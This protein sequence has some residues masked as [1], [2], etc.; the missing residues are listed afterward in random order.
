MENPAHLP[1]GHK[2]TLYRDEDGDY[3]LESQLEKGLILHGISPN[4]VVIKM[5]ETIPHWESF[6]AW[7]GDPR[8][9]SSSA[10]ETAQTFENFLE[11][12]DERTD[13]TARELRTAYIEHAEEALRIYREFEASEME[14]LSRLDPFDGNC[15][16]GS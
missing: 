9:D 5:V 6:K 7:G 3:V 14:I 16:A 13:E 15:T 10:K 2:F 4:D 11:M 12:T 1:T 8:N